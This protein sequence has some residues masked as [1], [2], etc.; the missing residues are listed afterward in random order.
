M[1]TA[2]TA[3]ASLAVLGRNLAEYAAWIA[4]GDQ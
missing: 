1:V 4:G 3:P 2:G